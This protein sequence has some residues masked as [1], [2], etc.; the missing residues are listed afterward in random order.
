MKKLIIA[1]LLSS[2]VAF[3]QSGT[4]TLDLGLGDTKKE[5][6]PEKA[7]PERKMTDVNKLPFT[8]D[9][10]KI[11]VKENQPAIQDCYNEM[12]ALTKK[13]V[14][15]EIMTSFIIT[16]E[17]VVKKAKIEKK[18]TTLRDPKFHECVVAT[19]N[20][21]EFPKPTDGAD[22]PINFPFKLTATE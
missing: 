10:I 11:V 19:L 16:P 6:P 13:K 21:M 14:Q 8:A 20:A 3:A 9:S 15:G 12:L 1:A 22:H 7:K 4:G 18:G 2:S 5:T 17:G